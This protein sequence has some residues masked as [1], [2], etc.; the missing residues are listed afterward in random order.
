M[1]NGIIKKTGVITKLK[2]S[3]NNCLIKIKSKFHFK[4]KDIGSSISCSG[5]CLTIEKVNKNIA[6]FYISNETIKKTIFKKSLVGD[7]LNLE[8]PLKYG[9]DIS[10]HFVQGHVDVTSQIFKIVHEGK[11]WIIS[12]KIPK[13]YHKYIVEK[14]SI[15]V[16]GVSL[17]ISKILRQGFQITI[18]PHTLK[19]TNLI[20]LKCKDIVNIEFDVLGKYIKKII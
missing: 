13:K 20:H 4:K 18:I 11:S 10:G 19:L 5:V 1:F 15:T 12:F 14:G 7:I 9:A 6:N 2:K 8:K 16:N 17:T 3:R